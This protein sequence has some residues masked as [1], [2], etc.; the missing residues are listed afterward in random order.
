MVLVLLY[1]GGRR[2]GWWMWLQLTMV[3]LKASRRVNRH[4]KISV[5][6]KSL[7]TRGIYFLIHQKEERDERFSKF[8]P[9][10]GERGLKY[11]LISCISQNFSWG[12]GVFLLLEK[13]SV[14]IYICLLLEILSLLNRGSVFFIFLNTFHIVQ[15]LMNYGQEVK[16]WELRLEFKFIKVEYALTS[17]RI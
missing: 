6:V 7:H 15:A 9:G 8:L 2:C 3:Y 13:K 5:W 16:L 12:E 11:L 4:F 14:Y 17:T 1:R 10:T